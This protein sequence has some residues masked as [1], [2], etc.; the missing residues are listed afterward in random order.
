MALGVYGLGDPVDRNPAIHN[1]CTQRFK[2]I[3][4]PMDEGFGLEVFGLPRRR[5]HHGGASIS[6]DE[7]DHADDDGNS[8]GGTE[9]VHVQSCD[10]V[11]ALVMLVNGAKST[12]VCVLACV[13][14]SWCRV[15]LVA[16]FSQIRSQ[17][18]TTIVCGLM[19]TMY[20]RW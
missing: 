1:K 2:H 3:E 8:C 4:E 5:C 15:M 9:G 12:I 10:Y 11:L 19:E 18:F 13:C 14:H 7:D 16:N 20:W 6:V 17:S